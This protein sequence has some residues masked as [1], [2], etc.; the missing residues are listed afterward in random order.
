MIPELCLRKLPCGIVAPATR[1]VKVSPDVN[2]RSKEGTV[3]AMSAQRG[4]SGVPGGRRKQRVSMAD[5]AKLAG[6]SSQTVSRVSNG[7]PGVIESTREQVLAAMRELGYRPNSAARALRYGRF[8]TIGVILFS[9]AS[10]GNSR[11]VE[12]IATHAA[13]EGYAITLIPIDVPTQDNVLGAFTRMGELAVDAVIVIIEIHLLDA[14]TVTLPPGVHVV[15][16]DSDAGDRYS[17]VD[18]DQ[19]DGARRAVHHLLDLGHRTV[20]H[21]TGPRAS[22]ASQ[23]R[24]DAWRA[25]LEAA[26]RPVPEPLHG[27]WSAESGYAA[28]LA[29]AG[30][31]GCTA[32]FA[33]NDQMAL[34]L[35]RAFHERGRPAPHGIS[36]VGFDDIPD[37][38]FFVPPLTT[39]HQ[40]FAEVGRRCVRRVLL[41][42]RE[43]QASAPGTD[44]VPTR[45]VVRSSTA[46]PMS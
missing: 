44:L 34:G 36:V 20:W 25:T 21:V 35:L 39:V 22:F 13:A 41:Q 14:G 27:D 11:T 9:L 6:V 46:A 23:R 3:E 2:G 42:I 10:T 32:V 29:L 17:V 28:G 24:A 8:N 15:V 37:A 1:G 33:A 5:V 38:A 31:P 43:N 45:L 12:A 4:G 7:H 16:V 30:E 26:G 19:A 40:D 18:T